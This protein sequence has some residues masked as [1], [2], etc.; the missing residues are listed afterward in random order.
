[1]HP[2]TWGQATV[3]IHQKITEPHEAKEIDSDEEHEK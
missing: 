3:Y 1:M 2:M